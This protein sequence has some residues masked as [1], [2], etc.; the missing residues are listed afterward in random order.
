MSHPGFPLQE[1]RAFVEGRRLYPWLW[2]ALYHTNLLSNVNWGN[3]S[4]HNNWLMNSSGKLPEAVCCGA[5]QS[6]ATLQRAPA[7]SRRPESPAYDRGNLDRVSAP[8][9]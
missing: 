9:L 6:R 8:R 1:F 7:R 4:G 2:H 3:I 5:S